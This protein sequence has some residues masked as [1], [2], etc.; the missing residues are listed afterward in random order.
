MN[1]PIVDEV[2]HAR[3]EHTQ[4]FNYDLTSIC[5]DLRSIQSKCGHKIVNLAPKRI[6]PTIASA[7]KNASAFLA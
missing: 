3:M 7:L 2:R 6:Q 5:Q 1:D 4:K